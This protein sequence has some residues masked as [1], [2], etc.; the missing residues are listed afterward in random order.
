MNARDQILGSIRRSL[1]VTGNEAPRRR[2]VAD[3]IASH[4]RGIIPARGQ[5]A[6]VSPDS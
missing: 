3:R 4:P 2:E 5:G 1:G 6:I